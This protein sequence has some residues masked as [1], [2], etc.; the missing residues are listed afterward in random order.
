MGYGSV[1][2]HILSIL[3]SMWEINT[4]V[5]STIGFSLDSD[6]LFYSWY[7]QKINFKTKLSCPLIRYFLK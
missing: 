2:V 1:K 7:Y 6:Y 4:W 5:L 3:G